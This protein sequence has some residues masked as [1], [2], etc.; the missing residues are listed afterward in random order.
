MV[1]FSSKLKNPVIR[2]RITTNVP[3]PLIEAEPEAFINK[4]RPIDWADMLGQVI[5]C[6][7]VKDAMDVNTHAYLFHGPAGTGKTSLARITAQKLNCTLQEIDAATHSGVADMRDLVSAQVYQSLSGSGRRAVLVDECQRLSKEAWDVLLKPMEEP[8]SHVYYMLC[9]TAPGKIP[10][11]IKSRLAT[12]ELRPVY[13]NDLFALLG[14][15]ADQEKFNIDD[16]ALR[17]IAAAAQ[18]SPRLALS[19][20][21]TVHN[22]PTE[23]RL[24]AAC[25]DAGEV[26]Q[27]I[28]LARALIARQATWPRVL[29]ILAALEEPPESIR[30]MLVNYTAKVLIGTTDAKKAVHL[31]AI[32]DAFRE[33]CHPSEKMA[34][35]L[36]SFGYLL[37]PH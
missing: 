37:I 12:I 26:P 15:V 4:Y 2:K 3:P 29:E 9:S 34:P 23:D 30:L 28:D 36:R 1:D 27:L 5:A 8:A 35:L 18:G 20:L 7:A 17:K 14:H 31:L 19:I 21:A 10:P 16:T 32:L 11:T 33:P 24:Q 6:E 25:A 13:S 22:N